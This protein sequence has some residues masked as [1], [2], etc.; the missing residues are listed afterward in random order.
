MIL[1]GKVTL[2]NGHEFWRI[3][4]A[5][6]TSVAGLLDQPVMLIS[7]EISPQAVELILAEL[8]KFSPE[9]GERS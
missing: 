3:D 8:A 6:H 7:D 2:P 5:P 1:N 9:Q 4:R